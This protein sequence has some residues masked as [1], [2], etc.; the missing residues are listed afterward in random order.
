MEDN[1]YEHACLLLSHLLLPATDIRGPEHVIDHHHQNGSVRYHTRKK[2]KGKR[3]QR[4]RKKSEEQS[5]E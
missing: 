2:T 5:E 1:E 4:E 3:E